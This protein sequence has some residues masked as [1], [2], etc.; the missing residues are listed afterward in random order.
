MNRKIE[1]KG[2]N[3]EA[4]ANIYDEENDLQYAFVSSPKEGR[5]Q[6]HSFMACRDY[7]HEAIRSFLYKKDEALCT[8]FYNPNEQ[9]PIDINALRLIVTKT[10][11][12]NTNNNIDKWKQK[13]FS[14]K[15][16]INMY[17]NM[18]GWKKSKIVTV[19]HTT[20]DNVWLLTGPKEWMSYP[21][22]VSM[23]TLILRVGVSYGPFKIKN[24][25]QLNKLW[26]DLI[27][28]RRHNYCCDLNYIKRCYP[29]FPI[30]MKRYKDIFI[31][32]IKDVYPDKKV[33]SFHSRGGIVSLCKFESYI[34]EGDLDKRLKKIAK[35][36]GVF[37]DQ[38]VTNS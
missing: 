34:E 27:E 28:K 12:T 3:P 18:A 10:F 29:F 7:I 9:P 8:Y 14:A 4:K 13:L 26:E 30:L 23:V 16:I 19:N 38:D 32:E 21:N 37:Q 1:V 6:C 31:K 22:L 20:K 11:K 17:E 2:L 25:S 36:E 35:E 24:A 33:S 5:K 15:A